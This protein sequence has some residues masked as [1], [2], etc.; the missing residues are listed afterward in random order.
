MDCRCSQF[1]CSI[2]LDT[3]SDAVVSRCGHLYCASCLKHWLDTGPDN[4]FCPVCKAA[5]SWREVIRVY[6][7]G[8]GDGGPSSIPSPQTSEANT[9][10]QQGTGPVDGGVSSP[11]RP[12]STGEIVARLRH[13]RE[14]LDEDDTDENDEVSAEEQDDDEE[15]DESGDA[16]QEDVTGSEIDGV[17]RADDVVSDIVE[18]IRGLRLEN[19]DL[20][21]YSGPHHVPSHAYYHS[22]HD[23]DFGGAYLGNGN[24]EELVD[25]P[26]V[27]PQDY[28]Q[29]D[30]DD[31]FNH[32]Y[33]Y[34]EDDDDYF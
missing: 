27:P 29:S 16:T 28:Y 10:V 30:Y 6:G 23:D 33:D 24:D 4:Q 20:E 17:G 19:D 2:C 9:A 8:D 12:A 21:Y 34:L 25:D 7:Q 31:D 32:D 11:P 1:G 3:A 15:S 14:V 18:V 5:I 22:E 26:Y 13:F